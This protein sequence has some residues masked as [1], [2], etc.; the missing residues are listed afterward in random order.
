M[1]LPVQKHPPT[2]EGGVLVGSYPREAF[3]GGRESAQFTVAVAVV[4]VEGLQESENRR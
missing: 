1:L 2:A 4:G 3:L